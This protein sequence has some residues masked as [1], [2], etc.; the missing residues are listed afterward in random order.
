MKDLYQA[1]YLDEILLR[2]NKLS[3]ESQHLWG[4]MNVNQMLTHCALSMESALGDKFYPQVLL[5]KL[6]GRFI[7]F[8]ISN[9]KPF[10]KNAPTNPSFVVTDTKEFNVEKEKL[11]DLTKKFSSGGEEKCTRNPHS[12]FGKIS[13]HEWGILMY[14]HIDHHLKQFNA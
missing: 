3:P 6:V 12:F 13:P 11:I 10:P 5:G 1:E 9:G 14:K 2:I 8:T 7:K 4:K